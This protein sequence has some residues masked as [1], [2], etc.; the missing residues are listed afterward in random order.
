MLYRI[1]QGKI[2][3]WELGTHVVYKQGDFIELTDDQRAKIKLHVRVEIVE[4]LPEFDLSDSSWQDAVK[5]CEDQ[6]DA[7]TL[8][9]LFKMESTG[10][11]RS[12][13]INAIQT[14]LSRG[15]NE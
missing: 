6:S 13:V 10:K 15:S 2:G 7:D 3:R 5:H 9:S 12:S 4:N 8:N 14:A 1:I 11:N